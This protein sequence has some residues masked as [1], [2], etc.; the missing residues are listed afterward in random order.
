MNSK[1]TQ[2]EKSLSKFYPLTSDV[3]SVLPKKSGFYIFRLA[4]SH[5]FGRL[6]GNSDILY[7]G[8]ASTTLKRRIKSYFNPGRSQKTSIRINSMM[9]KYDI[10]IAWNKCLNPKKEEA[11]LLENYF[12]EHDELPPFNFRREKLSL[13][14]IIETPMK[15][16][17]ITNSDKII[18]FLTREKE[19]YCDDCLS[20]I[21][22]IKPRQ[23]VNQICRNHEYINREKGK[24]IFCS[25]NKIVNK[26]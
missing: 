1:K 25:G 11:E 19:Q 17:R 16:N 18:E 21:L 20:T 15:I 5:Y 22:N 4:N 10:E 3:L 13:S 26:V 7:I 24:C 8:S 6:K 9:E 23:Q 14:K 12:S 2:K